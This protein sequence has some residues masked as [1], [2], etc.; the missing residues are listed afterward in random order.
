MASNKY[1]IHS[2]SED[3]IAA[4]VVTCQLSNHEWM[5]TFPGFSVFAVS[6]VDALGKL[7]RAIES[8]SK[9][10]RLVAL[11]INRDINHRDSRPVERYWCQSCAAYGDEACVINGHRSEQLQLVGNNWRPYEPKKIVEREGALL[12]IV[13]VKP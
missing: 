5:A 10:I 9:R 8:V 1:P 12:K 6:E 11:D 13:K 2:D 3:Q 7:A 4:Y